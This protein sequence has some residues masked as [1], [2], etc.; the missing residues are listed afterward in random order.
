MRCAVSPSISGIA[1]AVNTMQ[2]VYGM[3]PKHLF[4]QDA[5]LVLNGRQRRR[6]SSTSVFQSHRIFS[7]TAARP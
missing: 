6:F 7:M 4:R 1:E 5:V 2:M 3:I